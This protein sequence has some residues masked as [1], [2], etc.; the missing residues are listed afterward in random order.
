MLKSYDKDTSYSKTP[1]GNDY[2]KDQLEN[3]MS[4]E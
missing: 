4:E 1:Q 3:G 2:M